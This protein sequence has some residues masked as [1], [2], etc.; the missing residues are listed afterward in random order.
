VSSIERKRRE[1]KENILEKSS[2]RGSVQSGLGQRG[3][4]IFY[5]A[6]GLKEQSAIKKISNSWER[7]TWRMNRPRLPARI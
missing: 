1:R 4:G 7:D 2:L 3:L 6:M 5:E